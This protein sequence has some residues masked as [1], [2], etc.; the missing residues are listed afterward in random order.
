M[1]TPTDRARAMAFRLAHREVCRQ[2]VLQEIV[3]GYVPPI[4]PDL[5]RAL[6]NVENAQAGDPAARGE[7]FAALALT[8]ARLVEIQ[9]QRHLTACQQ[10]VEEGPRVIA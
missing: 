5:A 10:A 8:K 3:L 4:W 9:E 6:A 1:T 2:D 7:V